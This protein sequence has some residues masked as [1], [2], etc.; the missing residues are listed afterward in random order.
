MRQF[1]NRGV[2]IRVVVAA[3]AV[4]VAM[5]GLVDVAAASTAIAAP[6]IT[7]PSASPVPLRTD[8]SITLSDP[9]QQPVYY[10]VGLNSTPPVIPD[11][12]A[13][14]PGWTSVK[15]NPDGAATTTQLSFHRP[16]PNTIYAY[17][18]DS[19][20]NN[21][22][23]TNVSVDVAA[24]TTPD[25]LGDF[26]GDGRPD[27]LVVGSSSDPGL[28]LHAGTD[29]AGHVD[30]VGVQVG[31]AGTGFA[32]GSGGPADWTG[33][34]ITYGDF[35]NDGLQDI[36]VH[37]PTNNP[38]GSNLEILPGTG[39]G[40]PFAPSTVIAVDLP[41]TDGTAGD[42]PNIAHVAAAPDNQCTSIF[43]DSGLLAPAQDIY[44]TV[45]DSLYLYVPAA[46][47][48]TAYELASA[49]SACS[50]NLSGGLVSAAGW[51]NV[52]LTGGPSP[53]A[54]GPTFFARNT[55]TGVLVRW[56]GTAFDAATGAQGVPAGAPN[57]TS[58]GYAT[59]GW[60]SAT[61]PTVTAADLNHDTQ[62]D[63][64][65]TTGTG[66]DAFLHATDT[67]FAPATHTSFGQAPTYNHFGP[68][69]TWSTGSSSGTKA[70]FAADVN[71]DGAADL[72]A[73][74]GNGTRVQLAQGGHFAVPTTWSTVASSGTKATL[75]ADVNGDG[76]ADLIAVNEIGRASCRERV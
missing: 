6:T 27:L 18:I 14:P 62:A 63:L 36:L 24:L 34:A 12:T 74:N 20:G 22:E 38:N 69:A 56:V 3:V 43:T 49:D 7:P 17:A 32:G 15:A 70:T 9:G 28:W 35:N 21:S 59:S 76:A 10:I 50:S 13:P 65:A 52:E 51:S 61:Y 57:S 54:A 64:W 29:D 31:G 23:A 11:P 39:D 4:P 1:L 68:S 40:L 44:A 53:D 26:T 33:T 67:T 46:F 47:N 66:V 5:I 72:I 16:G 55:A 45:G 30:P 37:F 71:G 19:A 73:V 8:V 25:V 2:L 42:E 60:G 58:F 75:A 41:R 48:G